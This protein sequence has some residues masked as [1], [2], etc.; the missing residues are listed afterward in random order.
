LEFSFKI[1]SF[2]SK[3]LCLLIKKES[4]GKTDYFGKNSRVSLPLPKKLPYP[5]T[6]AFSIAI[7]QIAEF[8]CCWPDQ[9]SIRQGRHNK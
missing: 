9:P 8:C 2:S 7:Y 1:N 6:G 3:E 4:F 5:H